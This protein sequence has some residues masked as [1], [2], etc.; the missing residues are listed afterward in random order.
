L[1]VTVAS[2]IWILGISLI[3]NP[4]LSIFLGSIIEGT[5]DIFWTFSDYSRK[6][7]TVMISSDKFSNCNMNLADWDYGWSIL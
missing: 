1:I 3:W 4:I 7:S 2:I 6:S 5:F